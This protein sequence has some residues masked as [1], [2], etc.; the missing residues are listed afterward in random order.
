MTS[1]IN[2]LPARRREI[3]RT[4]RLLRIWTIAVPA[5]C[6]LLVAVCIAARMVWAAPDSA[7]DRE[8]QS[9]RQSARQTEVSLAVARKDLAAL[10]TRQRMV[11]MFI[12][13]PDWAAFLRLIGKP[14]GTNLVL[15]EVKLQQTTA[16]QRGST[17]ASPRASGATFRLELRGLARSQMDLSSYVKALEETGLFDEVNLLRTGREP[18]LTGTATSFELNCLV[19]EPGGK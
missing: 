11:S 7:D 18:F 4:R 14:L 15:R 13:Q 2:L 10:Q 17:A 6:V 19:I 1:L 12:D 9:A 8:L 16:N 5:Y 3:L